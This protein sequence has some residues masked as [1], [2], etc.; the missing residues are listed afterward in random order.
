MKNGIH[1]IQR[2]ELPKIRIFY[3]LLLFGFSSLT[4]CYL[5]MLDE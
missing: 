5:V 1:S 4:A 2:D 3:Y